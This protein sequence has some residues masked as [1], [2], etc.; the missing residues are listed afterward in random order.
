MDQLIDS[1]SVSSEQPHTISGPKGAGLE[2][3][4][5][6]K[7]FNP[8]KTVGDVNETNPFIEKGTTLKKFNALKRVGDVNETNPFIEKGTTLKKFN[9]LKTVGDVN[10]TNPFKSFVEVFFASFYFIYI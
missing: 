4:T 6:L 5:T 2:K 1:V 10:E 9:A 7:K 8:L 3:G